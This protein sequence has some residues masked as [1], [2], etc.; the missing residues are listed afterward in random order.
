MLQFC[1]PVDL[2]FKKGDIVKV[3]GVEPPTFGV[4]GQ[5]IDNTFFE[6]YTD[7]ADDTYMSFCVDMYGELYGGRKGVTFDHFSYLNYEI[8]SPSLH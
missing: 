5:D 6:H 8:C 7:Y 1:V 2:E 3:V 4:V